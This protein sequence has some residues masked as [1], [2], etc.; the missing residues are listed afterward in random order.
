VSDQQK[1]I[2]ITRAYYHTRQNFAGR[3]FWQILANS[4][5]FYCLINKNDF[6]KLSYREYS[7]IYYPPIIA[8]SSFAKIFSLQN[9]VLYGISM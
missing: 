2:V 7:P 5:K 9:F 3:K 8:D 6:E 4:P 1:H